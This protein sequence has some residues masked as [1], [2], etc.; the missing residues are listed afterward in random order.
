MRINILRKI[1][2]TPMVELEYFA[3]AGRKIYAKLE[4]NNPAGSI[5]DR[6]ALSMLEAAEN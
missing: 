5:K 4:G 2:D 1:G 6:I 3:P